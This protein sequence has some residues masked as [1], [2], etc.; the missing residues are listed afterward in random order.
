MAIWSQPIFV[1]PYGLTIDQSKFPPPVVERLSL[2]LLF[3]NPSIQNLDVFFMQ[4]SD[5]ARIWGYLDETLVGHWFEFSKELVRQNQLTKPLQFHFWCSDGMMPYILEYSEEKMFLYKG[6]D[7]SAA[8][9]VFR[10]QNY[11]EECL[12]EFDE[13]AYTK[14]V[15]ERPHL[16]EHVMAKRQIK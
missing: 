14:L 13:E 9:M 3:Q 16:L 6:N 2:H 7:I 5:C 8:F 10:P 12:F 11:P 1:R 15:D 4:L